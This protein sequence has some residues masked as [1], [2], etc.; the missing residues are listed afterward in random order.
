MSVPREIIDNSEENKLPTFLK[1]TLKDSKDDF[2]SSLFCVGE[3]G[4]R[5]PIK[6]ISW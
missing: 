6:D 4:L 5:Y 2:G 1:E 3:M